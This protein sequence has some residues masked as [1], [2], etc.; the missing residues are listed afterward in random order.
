MSA[1][2]D[3]LARALNSLGFVQAIEHEQAG[4][5]VSILCR[6]KPGSGNRWAKMAEMLLRQGQARANTQDF[7]QAHIART[8]M[9]RNDSLVYGWTFLISAQQLDRVTAIIIGLL[10]QGSGQVPI[11]QAPSQRVSNPHD[12]YDEAEE[13]KE[14]DDYTDGAPLPK[15]FVP[16]ADAAGNPIVPRENR[17]KRQAM[18]GLAPDF[19]RNAPDPEKKKGSWHIETRGGKPFRPPVRG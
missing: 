11:P 13:I 9:L 8:Y 15:G 12:D 4:T 6:I 10:A 7:W 1:N 2:S 16:E 5:A 18:A 3:K 14:D 19:D 17:V